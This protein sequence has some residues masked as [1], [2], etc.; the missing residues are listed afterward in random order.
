MNGFQRAWESIK[1]H[2][3]IATTGL[4]ALVHSTWTMGT[5][6]NGYQPM[7]PDFG[8][9]Q[10]LWDAFWIETLKW[11][12]PAFL[13]AFAFDVGQIVTSHQIRMAVQAGKR[14]HSKYVTFFVLA[15]A[16]YYMQWLYL[17]HHIPNFTFGSGVASYHVSTATWLKDLSLWV[18]PA[19]LPLSTLLYTFSQTDTDGVQP[20]PHKTT[21]ISII[22]RVSS[23]FSRNGANTHA[24]AIKVNTAPY[25]AIPDPVQKPALEPVAIVAKSAQQSPRINP[26]GNRTGEAL[27]SVHE[28][29]GQW[30]FTC[31][32]CNASKGY[33]TQASA[34]KAASAHIGR[35]CKMKVQ[36]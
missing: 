2:L 16:T 17:A 1:D 4:A 30:A 22:G 24:N 3:F 9:P 14:P 33:A 34:I 31:P 7:Q 10:Y 27:S 35:Y 25:R 15:I 19:F 18:I 28:A 5:I 13:I 21:A 26:T 11:H 6:F 29:D 12:V 23:L 32:Q 8:A 20:A 36:S